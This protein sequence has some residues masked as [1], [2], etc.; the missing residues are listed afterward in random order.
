MAP[1]QAAVSP[2]KAS[3]FW[4]RRLLGAPGGPCPAVRSG[5]CVLLASSPT[6]RVEQAAAMGPSCP[7]PP[8]RG[9]GAWTR[10]RDPP[11]A[12]PAAGRAG[13]THT[14][15]SLRRVCSG[16]ESP[17]PRADGRVPPAPWGCRSPAAPRAVREDVHR[18][19]KWGAGRAPQAGGGWGG[20]CAGAGEPASVPQTDSRAPCSP[21][22]PPGPVFS[23]LGDSA[24]E[25]GGQCGHRSRLGRGETA[26][27]CRHRVQ[28]ERGRP[29]PRTCAGRRLLWDGPSSVHPGAPPAVTD[30][31]RSPS[32][33]VGRLR[34]DGR[35]GLGRRVE[36]HVSCAGTPESEAPPRRWAGLTGRRV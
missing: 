16:P 13:P 19:G 22:S 34:A 3:E 11:W 15:R 6:G 36:S 31:L 21:G 26:L 5:A 35:A 7:I 32:M 18:A 30:A 8:W 9:R 2:F 1:P 4:P 33:A 12:G 20:A 24:P 29:R 17:A 23:P 10:T 28:Q 25:A 14:G 27:T